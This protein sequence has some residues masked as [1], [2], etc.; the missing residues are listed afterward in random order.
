M[1]SPIVMVGRMR[2]HAYIEA[3]KDAKTHSHLS[4][5][6]AGALVDGVPLL[7]RDDNLVIVESVSRSRYR[8]LKLPYRYD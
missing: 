7:T 6:L 5:E 2:L 8:H 4:G 3:A 1:Q